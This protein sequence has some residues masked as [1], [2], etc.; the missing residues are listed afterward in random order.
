MVNDDDDANLELDDTSR[1]PKRGKYVRS[2]QKRDSV[3]ADIQKYNPTI[4]H[5]RRAHAPNRLYLPAVL[6]EKSMHEHYSKTHD[7]DVSYAFYCRVL[8]DMNIS[9]VKLGHEQ[10]ESCIMS[11]QHQKQSGH[12]TSNED[13][14]EQ[15]S[16]CEQYVEHLRLANISR[17]AYREDGDD[18]IPGNVV[19]VVDL[20]KVFF[21]YMTNS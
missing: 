6:S 21:I 10:C 17:K 20:Q 2:T 5:Y 8:K 19:L 4:S 11:T 13:T 16:I 7:L 15:C 9:L 14:G 1:A 3:P 18:V 12:S